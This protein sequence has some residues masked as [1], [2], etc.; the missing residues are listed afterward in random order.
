MYINQVNL[1]ER[2]F[3]NLLQ[4]VDLQF[5]IYLSIDL[6]INLAMHK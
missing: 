1:V 4:N 6:S 2:T 3:L 5:N